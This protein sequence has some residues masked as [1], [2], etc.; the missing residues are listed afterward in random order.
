MKSRT[1]HSVL[2]FSLSNDVLCQCKI[3]DTLSLPTEMI[4]ASAPATL[5]D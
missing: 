3:I 4:L 5:L 1:S 2:T